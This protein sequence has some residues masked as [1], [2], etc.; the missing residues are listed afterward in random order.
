MISEK[1]ESYHWN[2]TF[3]GHFKDLSPDRFHQEFANDKISFVIDGT[4][5]DGYKF[6]FKDFQNKASAEIGYDNLTSGHVVV[7][8]NGEFLTTHRVSLKAYDM[9]GVRAKGKFRYGTKEFEISNARGFIEHGL[10]IY[11]GV[12]TGIS[13]WFNLHFGENSIHVFVYRLNI[14]GTE[15][16]FGEGALLINKQ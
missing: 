1:L 3:S 9:F 4:W 7:Y 5:K 14:Y 10:G 15:V 12:P 8:G 11:L 16:E 6:S 13:T 2:E